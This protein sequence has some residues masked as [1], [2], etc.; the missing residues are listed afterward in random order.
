MSS[1]KRFEVTQNPIR[2]ERML[3]IGE[4]V[5]LPRRN[6]TVA[7]GFIDLILKIEAMESVREDLKKKGGNVFTLIEQAVSEK[8]ERRKI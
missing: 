6:A 7:K 3:K 2:N 4:T 1:K 8:V 5:G